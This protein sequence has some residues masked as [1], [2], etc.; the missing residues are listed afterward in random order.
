MGVKK[1]SDFHH[2]HFIYK[3]VRQ[4]RDGLLILYIY[5]YIYFSEFVVI[6][7]FIV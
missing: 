6:H 4:L 2:N 3:Q 5:I 7:S 1:K